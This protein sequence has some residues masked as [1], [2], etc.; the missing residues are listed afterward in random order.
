MPC[1]LW[2]IFLE[3]K[4][5]GSLQDLRMGLVFLIQ[6]TDPGEGEESM[7]APSSPDTH[8]FTLWTDS[9]TQRPR[10]PPVFWVLGTWDTRMK[11][12]EPSSALEAHGVESRRREVTDIGLSNV[13]AQEWG[14]SCPVWGHWG[15]PHGRDHARM[16]SWRPNRY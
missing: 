11:V 3:E 6:R 5:A 1:G 12:P 9:P 2:G 15:S 14:A 13:G 7:E 16:E 8:P 4:K 10:A